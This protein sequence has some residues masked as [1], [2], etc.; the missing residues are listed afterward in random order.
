MIFAEAA[1][2]LNQSPGDRSLQGTYKL[3]SFVHTGSSDFITFSSL[4]QTALGTPGVP[5]TH[6]SNYGVYGIV[7]QDVLKAGGHKV[8]GFLRVG[9]AP[10]DVNF[11]DF[12]LDGG[13]NF[14]GFIPGRANDVAGVA[15]AYSSVSGDFTDSQHTR[16]LPGYSAETVFEAT[17][18]VVLAPWWSVQPDVQYVF[19][20]SGRHGSNDALVLGVRTAVSF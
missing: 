12:Y 16:N 10:S 5:R 9:G 1:Y 2:L 4:S 8:S 20:P 11:V 18:R 14:V 15:V 13:F 19:N 17:Y 6:G 3:G 7:D